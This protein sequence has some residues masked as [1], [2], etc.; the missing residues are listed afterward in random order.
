[1][2]TVGEGSPLNQLVASGMDGKGKSKFSQNLNS[3]IIKLIFFPIGVPL[4]TLSPT[5]FS[6]FLYLNV[7]E[8]KSM[9]SEKLVWNNHFSTL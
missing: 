2:L 7:F 6:V 8:L 4:V 5:G 3:K 1:L 9:I